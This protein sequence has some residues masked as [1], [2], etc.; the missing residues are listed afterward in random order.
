M[1]PAVKL[2]GVKAFDRWKLDRF[3]WTF[4]AGRTLRLVDSHPRSSKAEHLAVNLDD[5]GSSPVGGIVFNAQFFEF[6]IIAS[7]AQLDRA[8]VS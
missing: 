4:L 7:V 2:R 1:T 6:E 3:E 8:P 5:A